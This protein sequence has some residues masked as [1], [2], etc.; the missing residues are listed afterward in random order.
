MKLL[1][2][3]L[4]RILLTW[5]VAYGLGILLV[6]VKLAMVVDRF[7]AMVEQVE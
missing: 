5:L 1:I 6:L 2:V 7:L 3:E 4:Q